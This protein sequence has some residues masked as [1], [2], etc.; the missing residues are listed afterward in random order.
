MKFVNPPRLVE[1]AKTIP[2]EVG[3]RQV[4]H[5]ELEVGVVGAALARR[6]RRPTVELVMSVVPRTKRVANAILALN[7]GARRGNFLDRKSVV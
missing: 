2:P 1:R 4:G 7:E 5:A 3:C 6:I